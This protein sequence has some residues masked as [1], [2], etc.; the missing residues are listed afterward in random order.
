M[1]IIEYCGRSFSLRGKKSEFHTECKASVSL[2]VVSSFLA[3]QEVHIARR[4]PLPAPVLAQNTV[5]VF[6]LME[7]QA[8][9]KT[10]IMR[11]MSFGTHS[12]CAQVQEL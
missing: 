12:C 8:V 11:Q 9:C 3:K 2:Y 4:Q 6:A 10:L 5:S 1:H 7:V